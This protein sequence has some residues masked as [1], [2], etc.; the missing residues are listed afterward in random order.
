MNIKKSNKTIIIINRTAY[1]VIIIIIIITIIIIIE[2]STIN[3][4][5]SYDDI[6]SPLQCLI[7]SVEVYIRIRIITNNN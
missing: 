3:V 5:W 1:Y 4:L 7:V 2:K 6:V